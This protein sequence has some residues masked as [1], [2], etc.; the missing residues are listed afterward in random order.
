MNLHERIEPRI[1]GSADQ[2][3]H[4]KSLLREI[5]D[6]FA[7]GGPELVATELAARMAEIEQHFDQELRQLDASL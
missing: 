7:R 2:Q 5:I 3:I 4:C 6:S 1:T